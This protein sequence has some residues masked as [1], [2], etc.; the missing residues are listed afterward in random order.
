MDRKIVPECLSVAA[1]LFRHLY[2]TV[3]YR[4]LRYL[5]GL[6]TFPYSGVILGNGASEGE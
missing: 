3:V 2:V 4:D 6:E 1:L 5:C